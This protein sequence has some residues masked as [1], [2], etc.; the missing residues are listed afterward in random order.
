[1]I[2]LLKLIG[3]Y[4]FLRFFNSNKVSANSNYSSEQSEEENILQCYQC[5]T[6]AS[7]IEILEGLIPLLDSMAS[8]RAVYICKRCGNALD[9]F[10]SY[11]N[12][13]YL[14]L[15]RIMVIGVPGPEYIS[16][17]RIQIKIGANGLAWHFKSI[18]SDFFNKNKDYIILQNHIRS[19]LQRIFTKLSE[20]EKLSTLDLIS[21]C[22]E[23]NDDLVNW[24]S[25]KY[26]EILE[27]FDIK[28]DQNFK[29]FNKFNDQFS[30]LEIS[31]IRKK[32][33]FFYSEMKEAYYWKDL[34]EVWMRKNLPKI[35]KFD[36]FFKGFKNTGLRLPKK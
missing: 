7:N 8:G 32:L 13:G 35:A 28:V 33:T 12:K 1:M 23:I 16:N 27:K 15:E 10:E 2:K 21:L 24:R 26:L 36:I 25:T 14:L 11:S 20:V 6:T 19:G 9:F 30:E 4:A 17:G 22:I 29:K 5:K 34:D 18:H 3:S 31:E